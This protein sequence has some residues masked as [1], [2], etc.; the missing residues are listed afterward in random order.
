MCCLFD[1]LWVMLHGIV[2]TVV[3]DVDG[4]GCGSLAIALADAIAAD[5]KDC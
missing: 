5:G 3:V 1:G 2:V 4:G